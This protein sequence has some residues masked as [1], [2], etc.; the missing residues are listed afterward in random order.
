MKTIQENI[1]QHNSE[2]MSYSGFSQ[3][4]WDENH[5]FAVQAAL[6]ANRPLLVRGEPGVGKSSLARA[7]AIELQRHCIA[8]VVTAKTEPN[9]LLWQFDG[10]RRLGDATAVCN[11]DQKQVAEL[12]DRKKYTSPGVLWWAFQPKQAY[13]QFIQC[14]TGACPSSKVRERVAPGTDTTGWV[15]LIDEIDKADADVPNSLLGA[16][17]DQEFQVP[18]FDVPIQQASVKP[19]LII[20][21][22]NEERE[23]PPAFL[24]RCF[25]LHMDFPNEDQKT[26][27]K[28]RA[29]KHT[30]TVSDD[31]MNTMADMLLT[32]REHAQGCHTPGLAEYIDFVC[33]YEKL[34]EAEHQKSN[35]LDGAAILKRIA[36]FTLHKNARR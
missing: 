13:D 18:G 21:T 2:N 5:K 33:A 31:V 12:L 19:P 32:A 20:I 6:A 23:L 15:V 28:D 36:S 35:G 1:R 34:L 9:D 26:W 16:L 17:A 27:L 3:Y 14:P 10:V 22:T 30:T 24:R 8:E 29:R 4:Q 25:V 7:A 11:I